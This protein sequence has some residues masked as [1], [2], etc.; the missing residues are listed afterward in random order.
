MWGCGLCEEGSP[1]S[2]IC[3]LRQGEIG[4]GHH[5]LF[6]AAGRVL[7]SLP[8]AGGTGWPWGWWSRAS[9]PLLQLAVTQCWWPGAQGSA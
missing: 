3:T 4:P 5:V 6:G 8:C 2:G 9:A 7:W 1:V